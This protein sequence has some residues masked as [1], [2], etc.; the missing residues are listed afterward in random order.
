MSQ[1]MKEK[2]NTL[3]TDYASSKNKEKC[4]D[5]LYI[6]I[7]YHYRDF[8]LYLNKD[9]LSDM[10]SNLYPKFI[11]NIFIKYDAKK[12]NFYTF[13]CTCLKYQTQSFLRANRRKECTKEI[14][15]EEIKR[16][17]NVVDDISN[18]IA[19]ETSHVQYDNKEV[20][21]KV[22]NIGSI[23]DKKMKEELKKWFAINKSS[24]Q[25]KKHK[26]LIF[27][28]M[29]KA[30]PFLDDSLLEELSLYLELDIKILQYYVSSCNVE[31]M[32]NS[33]HMV[34][35]KQRRDKYF[36]RMLFNEKMLSK[37]GISE[38]DASLLKASKEYSI[39]KYKTACAFL[40]GN[41]KSISNRAVSKITGVSRSIIDRLLN[42][43]KNLL[44]DL[45]KIGI[46]IT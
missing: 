25:N 24:K 16:E 19:N 10:L 40:S 8:G 45:K 15:L 18:T 23:Q 39:K 9:E 3:Y 38:Y 32:K 41:I 14:L 12:S 29:C 35:A 6:L 7:Y 36:I 28:L 26:R 20:A 1:T 2:V 17:E 30:A 33:R 37:D 22:A 34:E 4:V 27:I 31:Y 43:I 44:E 46:H 21:Y 13:I 42:N 5:M 11:E